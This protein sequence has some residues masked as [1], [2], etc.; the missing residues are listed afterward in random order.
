MRVMAIIEFLL[1]ASSG[2]AGGYQLHTARSLFPTIKVTH[3][4]DLL[5]DKAA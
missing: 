4:L 2:K 5:R 3:T 1:H